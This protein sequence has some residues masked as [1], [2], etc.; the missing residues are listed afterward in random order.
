MVSE[1]AES[2]YNISR[3]F[4]DLVRNSVLFSSLVVILTFLSI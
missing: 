3:Y 4:P 1:I 2:T